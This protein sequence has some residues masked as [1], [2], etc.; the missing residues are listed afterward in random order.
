MGGLQRGRTLH[1]NK[2][3][4]SKEPIKIQNF[5]LLKTAQTLIDLAVEEM[6]QRNF[7]DEELDKGKKNNNNGGGLWDFQNSAVNSGL[8]GDNTRQKLLSG[9]KVLKFKN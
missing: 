4:K 6:H 9:V 7:P 2:K 8:T 3:K 5:Y 1:G